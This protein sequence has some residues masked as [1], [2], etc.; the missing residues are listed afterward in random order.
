MPSKLVGSWIS[1]LRWSCEDED[2]IVEYRGLCT[3]VKYPPTRRPGLE[4]PVKSIVAVQVSLRAMSKSSLS[5]RQSGFEGGS[6]LA[7]AMFVER[8]LR[9]NR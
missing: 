7:M 9:V 8:S 4:A 2:A 5:I 1:S 3:V 6:G